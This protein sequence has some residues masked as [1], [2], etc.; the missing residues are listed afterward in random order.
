MIHRSLAVG[1]APAAADDSW[2]AGE[3]ADCAEGSDSD[4]GYTGPEEQLLEESVSF[5]KEGSCP[6]KEESCP[7]E[8]PPH[9]GAVVRVSLFNESW[10]KLGH[11]DSDEERDG[12]SDD[13][14]EAAQQDSQS[15]ES[16]PE[17]GGPAKSISEEAVVGG[18]S[19]STSNNPLDEPNLMDLKEDYENVTSREKYKVVGK[20][21][22]P[23]PAPEDLP[24]GCPLRAFLEESRLGADTLGLCFEIPN[25]DESNHHHTLEPQEI[26]M[27]RLID[28][29]SMRK[30]NSRG[31]LD[32]L[33]SLVAEEMEARGFDPR[34]CPSREVVS[35]KVMKLYGSGCDPVATQ[36]AV[37]DEG[38]LVQKQEDPK[39]A[40]T[41]KRKS[42]EPPP[43]GIEGEA[44]AQS[45]MYESIPQEID[46]RK[47]TLVEVVA[48]NAKNMLL[49]LLS[50]QRIF[51]HLK[52]LVVNE[53][54]PYLPYKN[55]S[56]VCDEIMDG[57]WCSDTIER[58]KRYEQDPL[59][60]EVEFV[61]PIIMYV[62]KTGT[63][64]NQRYP[65][66]PFIFTTA[67]IRRKLRN[68]P[69]SWRPL[70]FIPDLETKSSAEKRFINSRVKGATAQSYHLCLEHLLEGLADVQKTGIVH[71]LQLGNT[72]KK[73]RLRPEVACIIND[74][75]SADM[76]T[77]RVPSHHYTRRV[78]R[79]CET[80][81]KECDQ[82]TKDC[83]FV[84][85]SEEL[86]RLF[87]TVGMSA[88]EVQEDPAWQN[89]AG[90]DKP[91]FDAAVGIVEKA[92]RELNDLSFHP[93]R[94]AFLARCIRF[95]LDPR[96]IW[97][98]NPI[99]LMH[100][101]QSGILMYLV[102]MVLDN[103]K[104]KRQVEL[105]RLVDKLFGTLR[106]K[107]RENYP[108]MNFTKGFSKLTM[109]TSDEWA[110]KL[111]VLLILLHTEEGSKIFRKAQTFGSE[112]IDLTFLKSEW[113]NKAE[114]IETNKREAEKMQDLANELEATKRA[115][116]RGKGKEGED[117]EEEEQKEE[118]GDNQ[119]EETMLRKCSS[120]DF[121]HLAESLLCFHA[122][123]KFGDTYLEDNGKIDSS[124][125]RNSVA[126]MLAMVRW[127]CPRAKGNGWK[128][129]KY[130]DLLH[131]AIDMERFGPPRNFDAGPME[132]GLRYWAKLPAMTSQTRGYSTFCKQVAMRTF[133]FQCCSKA[134]R[135]HGLQSIADPKAVPP[136]Q[137]DED[138]DDELARASGSTYIIYKD[139][140]PMKKHK[141]K[142]PKKKE[143]A[144]AALPRT[145]ALTK[146]NARGSFDVSPVIVNYLCSRQ[147]K[148]ELGNTI[149]P[150]QK[151]K[152]GLEYWELR[153]EASIYLATSE[154]R[155]VVRCHPNYKNEGAWYDWVIVDFDTGE[156]QFEKPESPPFYDK[157][158]VPCKVL[159]V[160][161][162]P[163]QH[164]DK[165]NNNKEVLIL[166]H[167]CDFRP[168]AKDLEG[169]SVLI[170]H[171]NLAYRNI[172]QERG[173]TQM[174]PVLSWVDPESVLTRCL[175]IEETPGVHETAPSQGRSK[176]ANKVL[177]VRPRKNWAK[178]FV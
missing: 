114:K 62:D 122:W 76:I 79:C 30:H 29:C 138:E 60:E 113:A 142:L 74:G 3:A 53:G 25:N 56:R 61:L 121:I 107:E 13:E 84:E 19:N 47:R 34:R 100:A 12:G 70:G 108:R 21:S 163:T 90:G 23:K 22:S 150:C 140:L 124:I 111:F 109:L 43:I 154:E 134:L 71:W 37:A 116:M 80:L 119:D 86:S 169:D 97:G 117:R 120:S 149:L 160:A 99:D 5:D 130:H 177:L 137:K 48:F 51:G 67:V 170:E 164:Q 10:M 65:L 87:R 55:T 68:R 32:G 132:S 64:M 11:E 129:Q 166:V 141:G 131:L 173:R 174:A 8:P 95:G 2:V 66:E 16:E 135:L 15:K 72:K 20:L 24:Q 102:K 151:D 159:A 88:K 96:N 106:C 35:K 175:V 118:V 28:Y 176:L 26:S 54:N 18:R 7:E 98:A 78:S 50:D 178:E 57:S 33:L 44:L 103:V 143:D 172:S 63:S 82:P 127:S 73:V 161:E 147:K 145:R 41:K 89:E 105:D 112:N 9:I 152:D 171:W 42:S 153:T 38:G 93:V 101:F 77:L 1:T 139:Q 144:V 110:G 6:D 133:E 158:C 136:D 123:Y 17:D 4:V 52:N 155:V 58:L 59:K 46:N 91:T 81:Q 165:G 45:A 85:L 92:K 27:L 167:G 94:N 146:K 39:P 168:K 128:L 49:D 157:A 40:P 75:K 115:E 36:I 162:H 126:R 69:S 83:K 14:D 31:F 125:I 104:P 156:I 148:E